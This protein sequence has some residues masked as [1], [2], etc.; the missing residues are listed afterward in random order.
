MRKPNISSIDHG[1]PAPR[2][3]PRARVQAIA[4]T[5]VAPIQ[6]PFT[7]RITVVTQWFA[8]APLCSL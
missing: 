4:N 5:P 7:L 6:I 1:I 3:S 8:E 2:L